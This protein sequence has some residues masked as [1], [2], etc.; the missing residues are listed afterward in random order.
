V[1]DFIVRNWKNNSIGVAGDDHE[2]NKKLFDE[3]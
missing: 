3:W 1:D 2:E